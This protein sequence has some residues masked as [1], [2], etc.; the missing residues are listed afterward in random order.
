MRFSGKTANNLKQPK[1]P[2]ADNRCDKFCYS[3]TMKLNVAV[4]NGMK[5][6]IM[7]LNEDWQIFPHKMTWEKQG[8]QKV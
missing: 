8:V 6:V 1:N 3:Y 2:A 7:C 4:K 5:N